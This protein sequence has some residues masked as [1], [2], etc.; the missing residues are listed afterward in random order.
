MTDELLQIA[1]T[2][3]ILLLYCLPDAAL[4]VLASRQ[5]SLPV[6]VAQLHLELHHDGQA[7]KFLMRLAPM[8]MIR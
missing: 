8:Y 6:G 2:E 7:H 1:R 4:D 5:V 3:G